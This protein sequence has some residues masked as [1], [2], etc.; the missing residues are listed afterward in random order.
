[1]E[2]LEIIYKQVDELIPYV[3]NSRTHSDMQVTQIAASIKEFG[4]TNPI[5]TDGDN[6]VIAG[7]GRL[8]A[9][10]KLGLEQ[11]PVIELHGLD[12][13]KKKAY[14]IAD[15]KLALNSGWDNEILKLELD[16]L[17]SN[18]FDFRIT[19]FNDA[20]LALLFDDGSGTDAKQ[21]W[22]GMPEFISED[23][24]YRK[25][26]VN[27]DAPDDVTEF[28]SLIGQSFTEKTKSV[29]YPEKM[30]RDLKDVRYMTTDD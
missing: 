18:N 20:E 2:E 28:F 19:G 25:V 3:N 1:M 24:C 6:G 29:W 9:A 21:E 10:K 8:L 13:I 7:H 16:L 27:F 14:I 12:E 26:I 5:L 4:F 22:T 30:N 17:E 23:P 15:N 11:V